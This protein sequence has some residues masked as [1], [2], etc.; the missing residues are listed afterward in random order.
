MTDEKNDSDNP[1]DPDGLDMVAEELN[2]GM[3]SS[4][5]SVLANIA[6]EELEPPAPQHV[7]RYFS[8]LFLLGVIGLVGVIFY[9]V[10]ARFLIPLFLA[11]LLVVI[12][13]PLHEWMLKQTKNRQSVAAL[14]TTLLILLAVLLP[15]ALLIVMAAAEGRDVLRQF[16][17]AKILDDIQETRT[18]LKLDLPHA[19]QLR[20]IDQRWI[21]M[22]TMSISDRGDLETQSSDLFEIVGASKEIAESQGYVVTNLSTEAAGEDDEN[23][24]DDESDQEFSADPPRESFEAEAVEQSWVDYYDSLLKT[25][26]LQRQLLSTKGPE[27]EP[28]PQQRRDEDA[29]DSDPSQANPPQPSRSNDSMDLFN[30]RLHDY[31]EMVDETSQRFDSFKYALLGGRTRAFAIEILNPTDEKLQGYARTGGTF[32]KDQVV[33]FGGFA[34]SVLGSLLLGSAIMIISLY[35]FL[36]DGP[37]MLESFKGLSPLDD[38]H[39]IALVDEFANVSRAV[40][41]ATLLSAL[42]QGI[43]AGIGFYF[44][45]LDSIFLLTLLSAVLAMVPFVGAAAVWVPCSLYLYFFMDNLPYAIGLAVYGVAVISMADNFIKP[46]VLHGTSNLHPLLAL[47]SVLGG[48]SALGPIG[49]L[50]GPM[51][52]VFLQTLL[53]ILQRELSIMDGVA[54]EPLASS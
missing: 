34:G 41:V 48:V 22:Q 14:L 10:M 16:N 35:F 42:A 29:T 54:E 27:G 51:V 2:S 31:R 9:W 15:M 37:A 36:L 4:D 17:S 28:Q 33:R 30:S 49:I 20:Q 26:E 21:G 19:N 38:A 8:F 52:V 46:Y 50:I 13:R 11:A 18:R 45:G 47:L 5:G 23:G 1:S 39:E 6:N 53:K 40:V 43:L 24:G 32:L 12:F 25:K 3:A 7:T 44:A